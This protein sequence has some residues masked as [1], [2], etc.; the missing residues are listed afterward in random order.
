MK[1]LP[2]KY[3][4]LWG[5]F[6]ILALFAGC[7]ENPSTELV[8]QI[9]QE[10][11][12]QELETNQYSEDTI[13][14]IDTS[15][16]STGEEPPDIDTSHTSTDEAPSAIDNSYT[17]TAEEPPDIN[18]SYTSKDEVALYLHLY[19]HLPPN[20]ITKQQAKDL[21]WNSKEGNLEEVAPGKSIGGDRFWNNEEILPEE[22]NR[23]YYEC[24]INFSGGYRGPER[25]VYSN[26]GWIYYTSDHY[27]SFHLLYP[28]EEKGPGQ[29]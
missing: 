23:E 5:L 28:K 10:S 25:L 2:G 12:V 27:E 16:T 20:Y 3:R 4:L 29:E 17:S 11:Q 26:D 18:G 14:D 24:D 13:F 1:K 6:L 19:G 8:H 15:P 21:G 7:K 22:N 9:Y